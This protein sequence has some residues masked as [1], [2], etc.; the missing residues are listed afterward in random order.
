M[1][2]MASVADL[3]PCP[4]CGGQVKYE[5]DPQLLWV[6]GTCGGP[7]IPGFRA[8]SGPIIE[9]L[10]G[11]KR[12]KSSTFSRRFGSVALAIAFWPMAASAAFL[13]MVYLPAGILA[14]TT[15]IA[16][17]IGSFMTWKSGVTKIA[18]TKRLTEEA[19]LL[20]LSEAV[21]NSDR[22]ISA[23][24]VAEAAQISVVRAGEMLE[25]LVRRGDL[26][27]NITHEGRLTYS[28]E[29]AGVRVASNVVDEAAELEEPAGE[30][31]KARVVK[32]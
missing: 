16:T 28:G 23:E 17:L 5:A 4:H 25:S 11:A 12:A 31:A 6:C 24:K 20:Y 15:A 18:E 8:S 14:G 26:D 1:F 27:L 9:A 7:V 29:A 21:R 19:W 13:L 2:P 32:Q 30:E 22:A 3:R 10:S